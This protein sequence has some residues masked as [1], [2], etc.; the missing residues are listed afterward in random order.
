MDQLLNSLLTLI[1]VYGY[2]IIIFIIITAYLGLP[3][4]LNAVLLA[5]GSFTVDGNLNIF[6]LI[7][8]VAVTAVIGDLF[9]Y[10]LG[11][12]FGYVIVDKVTSKLGLTHNR[13]SSTDSLLKRWG[14]GCIFMTRWLITPFGI[15]VNHMAGI[16]NYSFKH[17]LIS[18]TLGELLWSFLY[19]YLGNFFGANWQIFFEYISGAPSLL[20]FV[21]IGIISLAIA[22]RMWEKR[23]IT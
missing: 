19:I 7:P 1:L 9:G 11:K 2:P 12:R 23:E 3:I 8:L 22:F 10:Y 5:A 6:I 13:I 16:S 4:S 18:A 21:V 20:A 17:F 15:P 14:W